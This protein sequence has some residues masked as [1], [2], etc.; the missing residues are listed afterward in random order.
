MTN[1]CQCGH[2]WS[3]HKQQTNGAYGCSYFGCGCKDMTLSECERCSSCHYVSGMSQYV[4][5]HCRRLIPAVDISNYR[6]DALDNSAIPECCARCAEDNTPVRK[7][8]AIQ[9]IIRKK[10]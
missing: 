9:P 1:E 10:M 4:C 6:C 5:S 3:R 7:V 2:L 8:F